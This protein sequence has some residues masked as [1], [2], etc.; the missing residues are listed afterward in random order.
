MR[1]TCIFLVKACSDDTELVVPINPHP[2]CRLGGFSYTFSSFFPPF[3]EVAAASVHAQGVAGYRGAAQRAKF[4]EKVH[5]PPLW[6]NVINFELNGL[7]ASIWVPWSPS[8]P[9][10]S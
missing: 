1:Y 2:T 4:A 6:V 9:K 8:D 7:D 5:K 10:K 3:N